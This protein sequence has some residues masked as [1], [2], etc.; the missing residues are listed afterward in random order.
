MEYIVNCHTHL[1]TLNQVPTS[2]ITGQNILASS[3]LSRYN[4]ASLLRKIIPWSDTDALDRLATFLENGNFASQKDVFNRLCLFYPSN[5]RFAVHTVD[6]EY[7][8][9]GKTP[10][11]Y[12]EQL[13]EIADIKRKYPQRIYPFIGIDPR[14]PGVFDLFRQYIE[15]K[16]F[17]G[18]KLYTS[19]GFFPFDERL[20]PIYEYAEKYQIP[21]MTHCSASGPVYG[22]NIPSKKE[23]IHPKTN[24]PMAYKNKKSFGD[25]YANPDN[26]EYVLRDFP[27]LKICF[28][29]FGGDTQCLKYYKS[30]D[31]CEIANN[32]FVKVNT[33]LKKYRNTYADISYSSANFDLLV[34]FNALLQNPE[35]C[36]E[37]DLD[38]RIGENYVSRNKI[39]FGSDFYMSNIERNERWFSMNI[40]MGLGEDHYRLIAHTNA[41]RYL[42]ITD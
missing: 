39:L 26:Y 36:K 6:F 40:R 15:E 3:Q 19:M 2:F 23:R 20:Y 24:E 16:D 7:M 10:Q 41:I 4:L 37:N 14:R 42:N 11:S 33:L 18:I 31:T 5:T 30:N 22:R 17:T 27:L 1:F 35:R 9:A 28:A 25:H 12:L 8:G 34:L 13:E 32:W 29:H 38:V 21:I